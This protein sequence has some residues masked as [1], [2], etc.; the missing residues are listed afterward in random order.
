[1]QKL[2][3]K[4]TIKLNLSESRNENVRVFLETVSYYKLIPYVNFIKDNPKI[5]EKINSKTNGKDAWDAV[6]FLYRYNIKLSKSLYHYIYLLETTIKTKVNNLLCINFG[7]DWYANTQF[8]HR[9]NKNSINY[10][11]KKA[12][13][14]INESNN[15]N[16]MDFVENHTTFGY[17]VA[18]IESGNLWNS[19]NIKIRRLFSA[20]EKINTATLS[21]KNIANT[22]KNINDLRNCISHHNQI[23]GCKIGK[24][25]G[26]E[27]N[28]IEIYEEM[29]GIFEL[30]GC[31]DLKWMIGD[32]NCCPNG[33][34]ELLYKEFEFIHSCD[35]R[36]EKAQTVTMDKVK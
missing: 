1:M 32:I 25:G 18:I 23:I 13:D 29:L 6:T 9:A 21:H 35:I 24:K 8:I 19:N 10:L 27:K 16:I 11:Q 30:L 3:E 15:P 17:W 31:E 4:V 5:A 2:I 36:A 28:I 14:Y 22:L 34:F 7:N 33:T 20:N 26:I 12:A